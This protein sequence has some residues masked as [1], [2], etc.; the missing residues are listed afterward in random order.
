MTDSRLAELLG[1]QEGRAVTRET[2]ECWRLL[3]SFI[4]LSSTQRREII[5]L[6]EKFV[7][8]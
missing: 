2:L 6:V 7:E 3:K 8:R 1:V 5:D 4:K